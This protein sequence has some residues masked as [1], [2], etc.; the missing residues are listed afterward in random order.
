MLD[1]QG[2]I[3]LFK[4][5]PAAMQVELLIRAGD[6]K[7]CTLNLAEVLDI[8]VRRDGFSENE[9]RGLVDPLLQ[10]EVQALP[11]TTELAFSAVM[12]RSRHYHR[13]DR[14]LSLADCVALAASLDVGRL[15]TADALLAQ[16]AREEGVEVAGLP[17]ALGIVP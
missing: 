5:E 8:L 10:K 6:A 13:R 17:N 1:A 11:V 7:I 16:I 9:I 14:P 4:A 15:A 12:L 2:L 3:A